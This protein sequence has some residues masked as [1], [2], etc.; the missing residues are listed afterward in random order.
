[1]IQDYLKDNILITDGAMGTYYSQIAQ[2]PFK[3]CEMANIEDSETIENIHKAYIASGTN[4]IRTNTFSANTATLNMPFAE[5]EKVITKGYEIA[6]K[7]CEGTGVFVGA[8]IGP[9]PELAEGKKERIYQDSIAEYKAIVDT[10]LKAGA[11][12]FVFETFSCLS[13]LAEITDYIKANKK[14]SFVLTQFALEIDGITRKGIGIDTIIKQ[15]KKID[16][17]DA[18]GFNCGVGP[19]HLYNIIKKVICPEDTVAVLPNAGYPEIIN[20]RTVYTQNPDYFAQIMRKIKNI[21]VRIVGGCCGTT[22]EH[23]KKIAETLNANHEMVLE[24]AK[25][26]QKSVSKPKV[27]ESN[28]S[29]KVKSNAFLITVELSPPFGT[30]LDKMITGAKV[31]KENGVD[32]ITIPD[33][34]MAKARADSVMVAA[35][36][37][38][39]VGIE[40]MPHICC[41]DRNLVSL[42]SSLLAAHIEGIRNILAITGDPIPEAFKSVVKSVFNVNSFNLMEMIAQMN[43]EVFESEPFG[44][45]GA[46][47]LNAVNK[48]AEVKRMFKKIDKGATFFLTQPIFSEEAI[49]SLVDIKRDNHIKI[50]GGIMPIVTYR[51]AQFINN[52]LPGIQIPTQYIN[53]FDVNMNRQEAEDVGVEMSVE[54]ANK[55]RAY[56]DGFYVI[57]PFNRYEMVVRILQNIKGNDA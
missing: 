23:I 28:F 55:M 21:G 56:V 39:E 34:P 54:I 27:M 22:P 44:I 15:V 37:R 48:Q 41:R 2:K 13:Y 25:P 3:Y 14:N 19:T 36:I 7:A 38:R 10:F 4:L 29:H 50:L 26:V 16:S 18:Y 24:D 12:I 57:T 43:Q 17:I 31:L 1:M 20:E 47:N 49:A 6:I 9:M 51:N 8:S 5:I 52:E 42:K 30:C 46:L 33:S 32:M 53:R 35:K 45:A 40:A 11:D